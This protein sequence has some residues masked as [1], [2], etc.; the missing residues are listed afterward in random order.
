VPEIDWTTN[1]GAELAR[2]VVSI[3]KGLWNDDAGRRARMLACVSRYEGRRL[4]SLSPQ[5]YRDSKDL[6]TGTDE[7]T[8]VRWNLARSLVSTATSKI[9]GGQQPKVSFVSSNADWSTRRKGPKLDA[10]VSGLWGTRQEPYADV[11]EMGAFAFRDAAICGLGAIKIWSDIDAGRVV[12]ERV[13]PWELLVDC[14][15]AKYGA[16]SNLFHVYS[17]PR[18]TLKALFPESVEE[19]A[20]VRSDETES[21]L[22]SYDAGTQHVV[23]NVRCFEWW[24]LPLGPDAP[25]QHVL[26]IEG[27]ALIKGEWTRDAFPFAFIR[28]DREFQGWHGKS[29]IEEVASIDDEMNDILGRISTTVRLTSIGTCYVNDNCEVSGSI[30]DNGDANVIKYSG[31]QIPKYESPAPFGPEHI[32]YLQLLKGAE[33]E[34]SGI[35]Q[36][37]AT[38]QK[39]PG[40]TANSAIRTLADLQS[41]RFAVAWKAYQSLFVEI[42]RHDIASVRELAEDDKNFAVKWPGSGFL[43]SIKWASVDLADDMYV[44]QIASAPGVKGTPADR[45]Q[46][47][48]E[49]FAAGQITQ[50]SLIAIQQSFDLPGEMD[51]TTRQRNV[52]ESYIEQWLDATPGELESNKTADGQELFKPPIRWMRLEDA[53]VQVADAYLQAELDGAP[54]DV[55]DLFL[56]WIELADAEIQKKAARMAELRAAGSRVTVGAPAPAENPLAVTPMGAQ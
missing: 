55:K 49:M 56:R 44:I 40:V 54:D 43:K 1:K 21:E 7:E 33:Y 35:N 9:A 12:H 51:R 50:D 4:S 6:L 34:L 5:A 42:A 13:F 38:A 36:M 14:H 2:S 20:S 3:G 17:V 53:L 52:I 26:A 39:Q 27:C 46:T 18:K 32:E 28:W 23:D 41:E 24:S 29:L 47:A 22:V 8:T 11:W 25:G 45:L 31:N 37:S 10:F 19:I 30:I 16:P 15:D 48:T